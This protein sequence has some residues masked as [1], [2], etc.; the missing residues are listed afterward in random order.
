MKKYEIISDFKKRH[1][2]VLIKEKTG[3]MDYNRLPIYSFLEVSCEYDR[4]TF[5]VKE[6]NYR[7]CMHATD[8]LAHWTST[9]E[10]YVSVAAL[11]SAKKELRRM[12]KSIKQYILT[13]KNHP[14]YASMLVVVKDVLKGFTD[15]FYYHDAFYLGLYNPA[16]FVWVVGECHTVIA[17]NDEDSWL[18]AMLKSNP[19]DHLFYWFGTKLKESSRP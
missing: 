19:K 1:D 11:E 2:A 12:I 17:N 16:K 7:I 9:P 4:K 3:D 13:G 8:T 10:Y 14:A 5:M 18:C 6:Y 15:D